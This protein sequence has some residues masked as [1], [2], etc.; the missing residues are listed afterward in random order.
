[1]EIVTA[2]SEKLVEVFRDG[3][4]NPHISIEGSDTILT[5]W[6]T[7]CL[8]EAL[9]ETL[10]E[11]VLYYKIKQ[12]LMEVFE[13]MPGTAYLNL[14]NNTRIILSGKLH[15]GNYKTQFTR[16][17]FAELIDKGSI[18]YGLFEEEEV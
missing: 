10:K 11:P 17:E 7:E 3:G 18:Y 13:V 9:Q 2:F 15:Q 16:T 12:N 14:V 5:K 6:E 1:M 4:S 8:I